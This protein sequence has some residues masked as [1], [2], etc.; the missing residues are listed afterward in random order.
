MA[1]RMVEYDFAI[2]LE[3]ATKKGRMYE[4]DFPE[5]CVIYLRCSSATPDRLEVK[6]NLPNGDYFIYEAKVVKVQ[7]YTKDVIF[8]KKLLFFLPYY[9]MRYEKSLKEISQDSEKL[10][11][12]LKE[13]E[14]IRRYL[15]EE[16]FQD[17]QSVLYADLID[18]MKKISNYILRKEE[19]IRKGIGD[20]MGGKVLELESERLLR[21]GRAE[22]K[23]EGKAEGEFVLGELIT[24]LFAAGRASD[25]E[26]AAKD[27]E[28]RKRF[29][30][31]FGM[32][33]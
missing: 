4:M 33:D 2:A 22:G 8:Q 21:I 13:Y 17:N 5:S 11:A 31:E 28:V 9:I 26:L 25:A 30:K 16:L 15:E 24:K 10:I 1:V 7:N 18:L 19:I 29:Y 32:I 14:D 20:V 6:V 23:A 27:A 3:Q 12:L